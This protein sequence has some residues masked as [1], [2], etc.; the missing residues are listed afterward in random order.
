MTAVKWLLKIY[1][2][3][4]S[5][6]MKYILPTLNEILTIKAFF[7]KLHNHT[8]FKHLIKQPKIELYNHK[9]SNVAAH[10]ADGHPSTIFADSVAV[11]AI[12]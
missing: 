4:K 2:V 11:A 1:K 5:A 9:T 6:T 7:S 3:I 8:T 12:W 10:N